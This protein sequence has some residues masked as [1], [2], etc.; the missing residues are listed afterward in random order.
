LAK[1]YLADVFCRRTWALMK[2]PDAKGLLDDQLGAS[3]PLRK[4]CL[5][6]YNVLGS[7]TAWKAA[8][9]LL[10]LNS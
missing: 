7:M 6:V 8:V 2:N 5:E 3:I 9:I 10:P 1:E 4:G